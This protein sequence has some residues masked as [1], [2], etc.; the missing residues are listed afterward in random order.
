[1][2]TSVVPEAAIFGFAERLCLVI[3]TFS[4]A[5]VLVRKATVAR[6][7]APMPRVRIVLKCFIFFSPPFVWLMGRV[8]YFDLIIIFMVTSYLSVFYRCIILVCLGCISSS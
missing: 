8:G 5:Q 7:K 3:R 4:L 2:Q 6:T 1:M